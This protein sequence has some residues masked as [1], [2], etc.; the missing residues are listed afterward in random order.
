MLRLDHFETDTMVHKMVYS[1]D[2]I[3]DGDNKCDN[4]IDGEMDT[5]SDSREYSYSGT[6]NDEGSVK[7]IL[8]FSPREVSYYNT[9][10]KYFRTLQKQKIEKMLDIIEGTS[11]ISLRILDWFVTK[12]AHT[13]KVRYKVEQCDEDSFHVHLGYKSQLKTF[14]KKY[15]DPFRRRTKFYYNYD[16]TYKELVI[17]TT[18]GQ[19]N[20]FK[21]AF[22]NKVIEYVEKHIKIISKAMNIANK[23]DKKRKIIKKKSKEKELEKEQKRIGEEKKRRHKIKMS[24]SKNLDSE[25]MKITLTFD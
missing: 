9:I 5:G 23:E 22:G 7:S 6:G 18:I 24:M 15:F 1:H 25:E 3:Y 10:D 13:N 4:T 21:W 12:Y 16:K 19:L 14:K 8:K 2:N 20:F 17:D 11:N